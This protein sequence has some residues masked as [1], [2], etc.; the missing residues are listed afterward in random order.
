M[1]CS[2]GHA[3]LCFDSILVRKTHHVIDQKCVIAVFDLQKAHGVKVASRRLSHEGARVSPR[4]FLLDLLYLEG[5]VQTKAPLFV[6]WKKGGQLRG[7]IGT[8]AQNKALGESLPQYALLAAMKDS[9]FA[10]VS[11]SE[12][13]EL[14]CSVSILSDFESVSG[15]DDWV[16]GEHGVQMELDHSNKHYRATF[17]PQVASEFGWDHRTTML[18]LLRKAGVPKH[19]WQECLP[20]LRITRYRSNKAHLQWHQYVS[21]HCYES[22]VVAIKAALN[23]QQ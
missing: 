2:V 8:F 10:P 16:I 4:L 1:V 22:D 14:E 9:R 21:E 15:W 7:C 5:T 12:V 11:L 23:A 20:L 17:L 6:T 19:L 13:P 18:H 3:A